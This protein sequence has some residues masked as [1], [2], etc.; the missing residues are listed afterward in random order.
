MVARRIDT[1][2]GAGNIPPVITNGSR[3]PYR[4]F[5]MGSGDRVPSTC[6]PARLACAVLK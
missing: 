6:W 3:F 2:L 4:E 1:A 5:Y